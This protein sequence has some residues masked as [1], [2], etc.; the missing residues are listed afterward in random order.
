AEA[1]AVVLQQGRVVAQQLVGAQQQF[2]EVDQAGAVAALLVQL[3]GAAHGLG[4]RVVDRLDVLRA[5]ALVLLRVDPPGDLAWREAALVQLQLLHHAL[6]QALLVVAVEH[7]EGFGQLRLVPVQA[8]QAMGDAVEGTDP[9]AAAAVAQ[10][11]VGA[12][13]HLA[14]GLVGEGDREDPVRR[15]AQD[16][17]EP[18]DAVGEDA[19]LAGA[20]TGQHEVMA[21]RGRDG[22]ALGAVEAVEKV[23]D[24]HGRILRVRGAQAVRRVPAVHAPGPAA[25]EA[26]AAPACVR[27][28]F[29]GYMNDEGP[30]CGGPPAF[31][32][33]AVAAGGRTAQWLPCSRLWLLW[34]ISLSVQAMPMADRMNTIW[35]MVC[36]STPSVVSALQRAA[37]TLEAA[38]ATSSGGQN[39]RPLRVPAA[40]KVFSR[41]IEEMPMIAI[42]SFTF[43]TEAL[44]WLSHSGWSGWPSRPRRETKVS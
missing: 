22:L 30:P 14:G 26:E 42:A 16:F 19:G 36:H 23:G 39:G 13:A 29:R 2:G 21:G 8:Q 11:Q 43:S 34:V 38:V 25:G 12:R 35:M 18:G 32:S 1:G 7:L 24:I 17:I 27:A 33:R 6:D 4:P 20:G 10:L 9:H 3:V 31:L 28:G 5:A 15:H 37:P 40:M 44:T 41:W